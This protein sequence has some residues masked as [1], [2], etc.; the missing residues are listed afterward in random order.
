MGRIMLATSTTTDEEYGG[1][2]ATQ[3]SDVNYDNTSSGLTATDV[4]DAIDE[5]SGD[6]KVLS[7][8]PTLSFVANT[9][10][11]QSFASTPGSTVPSGYKVVSVWASSGYPWADLVI[12]SVEEGKANYGAMTYSSRTVSL[13]VE[14]RIVCKKA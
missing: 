8:T 1:T 13:P 6:V 3:A 7:A 5:L 11:F 14:I 12:P 9:W 10:T 2:A 4:Q